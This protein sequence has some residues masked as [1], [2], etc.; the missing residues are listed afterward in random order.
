MKKILYTTLIS[1]AILLTGCSEEKNQAYY[2]K[3]IDNAK[4]KK[5]ECENKLKEIW[6]SKDEKAFEALRKDAECNAAINAIKEDREIKAE[7]ERQAKEAQARIEIDKEK[8]K[9]KQELGQADWKAVAHYVVNSNCAQYSNQFSK[10]G[11][12]IPK[13]NYQCQAMVEIYLENVELAKTDLLKFSYNDLI[14]Q[15]KEYCSKDKRKLSACDIWQQATGIQAEKAFEAQTLQ[16]LEKQKADHGMFNNKYPYTVSKA[17]E[18]AFKVKE[19]AVIENYT[20]NY[21]LLKQDYNQCVEKLKSIGDHYSK[22][23]ERI[24]VYDFYPCSQAKDARQKL[25]LP[26]DNFKTIME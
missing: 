14:T 22:S 24:K 11:F 7:Q 17:F 20:K 3:N 5:M 8:A 1:S 18:K 25:G 16:E 15:E 12:H 23:E 19:Q 26:Y 21:D 2:L 9:I 4:A 13:D 10:T 6:K